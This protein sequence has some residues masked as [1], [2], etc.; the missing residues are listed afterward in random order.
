MR[1]WS[2]QLASCPKEE[3]KK[4][5]QKRLQAVTPG[6]ETFERDW[7]IPRHVVCNNVN[8]L[9]NHTD[10]GNVTVENVNQLTV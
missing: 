8:C 2:E 1:K 4:L 10:Q 6:N 9:A 7:S 3:V 5:W